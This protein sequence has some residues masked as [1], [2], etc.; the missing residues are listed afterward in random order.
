MEQLKIFDFID[1]KEKNKKDIIKKPKEKK[2]TDKQVE[3]QAF[4]IKA[5]KEKMKKREDFLR[6]Y[7]FLY[8]VSKSKTQ[9]MFAMKYEDACAFCQEPNTKGTFY[10]GKW[11]YMF[12]SFYNYIVVKDGC[13]NV[14]K[15][16]IDLSKAYDDGRYDKMC[17]EKGW[18][19][20]DTYD[21][22]YM[23]EPYG[24]EVKPYICVKERF[25]NAKD[26]AKDLKELAIIEDFENEYNKQEAII[27]GKDKKKKKKLVA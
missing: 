2:Y 21:V 8:C 19:K 4:D 20:Y 23:L 5:F 9:I 22:K 11:M 18:K 15:I 10:D 26:N 6:Q 3:P 12:T 14:D 1:N 27:N 17:E 7:A 25:Q 16:T 24:I 13:Y